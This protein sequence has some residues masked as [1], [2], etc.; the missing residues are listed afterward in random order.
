MGPAP[1]WPLREFCLN[2]SSSTRSLPPR[3]ARLDR[4]FF[5]V[6]RPPHSSLAPTRH[7]TPPP[8]RPPLTPSDNIPTAYY[9]TVQIRAVVRG[10]AAAQGV[11]TTLLPAVESL[12]A[13]RLR[14]DSYPGIVY[15]AANASAVRIDATRAAA[16]RARAQTDA[17]A[18][19]LGARVGRLNFASLNADA[20]DGRRSSGG[21]SARSVFRASVR[22]EYYVL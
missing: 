13:S 5:L 3:N 1:P 2:R 20:Y 9:F 10:L 18:A 17:I 4:S 6:N 19:G 21:D 7:L 8:P 22:T 14:I 11:S 12:P 16:A 15:R